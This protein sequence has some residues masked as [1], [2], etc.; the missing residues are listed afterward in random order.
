[1]HPASLHGVDSDGTARITPWGFASSIV[2]RS[3]VPESDTGQV[4]KLI[5]SPARDNRRH[6][7]ARNLGTVDTPSGDAAPWH[8]AAF[9]IF[10][11]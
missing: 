5:F 8:S 1:M 4:Q 3:S 9:T 2:A 7:H 11:P 10:T 6:G